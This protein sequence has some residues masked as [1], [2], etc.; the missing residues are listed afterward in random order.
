MDELVKWSVME[1]K[2]KGRVQQD[3]QKS[4]LLSSCPGPS[5]LFPVLITDLVHSS[6]HPT[7]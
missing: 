4:D 6:E 2:G 5:F 3:G 7:L 1:E